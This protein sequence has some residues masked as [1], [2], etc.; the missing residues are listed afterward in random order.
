MSG[1]GP[2]SA[3]DLHVHGRKR[4]RRIDHGEGVQGNVNECGR[5]SRG[6]ACGDARAVALHHGSGCELIR[7]HA[8]APHH[9]CAYGLIRAHGAAPHHSCACELVHAHEAAHHRSGGFCAHESGIGIGGCVYD[10]GGGG[11]GSNGACGRPCPLCVNRFLR[12][13][14]HRVLP[15]CHRT[16]CHSRCH[17]RFHRH[18]V[19]LRSLHGWHWS[20]RQQIWHESVPPSDQL[21]SG[22]RWRGLSWLDQGA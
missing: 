1:F 5:C 9:S 16:S 19:R 14:G 2:R 7:A 15:S 4:A 8:D 20:E 17:G 13:L 18:L 6:C 22:W 10:G 12:L 3:D 11:D 21:E